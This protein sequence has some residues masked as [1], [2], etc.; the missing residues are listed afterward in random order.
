[1]LC[2]ALYP[3]FPAE[4][5]RQFPCGQSNIG[6]PCDQSSAPVHVF[7]GVGGIRR[8]KIQVAERTRD[9]VR[10]ETVCPFSRCNPVVFFQRSF[11]VCVF[12]FLLKYISNRMPA[13]Q[14]IP[15]HSLRLGQ[16]Q[17]SVSVPSCLLR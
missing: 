8:F 13:I 7:T 15:D 9:Y 12:W 3:S 4:G 16:C 17:C 5:K 10:S 14:E 2:E 1:M 6:C 11:A